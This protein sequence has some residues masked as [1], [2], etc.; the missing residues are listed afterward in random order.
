MTRRWIVNMIFFG[1]FGSSEHT[2]KG[3]RFG[4]Y[5]L[6][7]ARE[8]DTRRACMVLECKV[9]L[10]INCGIFGM[11]CGEGQ[12]ACLR[13][14]AAFCAA[15]EGSI[16]R[17]AAATHGFGPSSQPAFR[18]GVSLTVR[19]LPWA[20]EHVIAIS[21]AKRFFILALPSPRLALSSQTPSSRSQAAASQ[22]G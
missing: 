17:R 12:Q 21:S 20:R 13:L 15:R 4:V 3:S 7:L 9:S 5:V 19:Q 2:V 16:V 22:K 1:F 14:D 10:V 8:A 11:Y 18:R 6:D